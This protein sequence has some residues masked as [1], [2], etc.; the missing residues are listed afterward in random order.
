MVPFRVLYWLSDFFYFLCYYV[1]RYRR[2][3]VY[4]NIKSVFPEKSEVERK[5]LEKESYQWFCDVILESVKGFRMSVQDLNEHMKYENLELLRKYVDEKRSVFLDMAHTG[6]WEWVPNIYLEYFKDI[7]GAELYRHVKNKH[8][9]A[10]LLKAR[11]R[12]GTLVIPKDKATRPLLKVI[13]DGKVFAIGLVADQSP[14]RKNLHFWVPFLNHDTPFLQGPERLARLFKSAV[15]YLDFKRVSRGYYVCTIR[16]ITD[17]ASK[18]DEGYVTTKFAQLLESSI[19]RDP[20]QW[21]WTH[22]RWKYD[23]AK[24]KKS[25]DVVSDNTIG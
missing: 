23:P 7:V 13:R 12:F 16:D 5:K 25:E 1:V 18:T 6:A 22:R 4:S 3:V 21:F 9:D 24:Y 19:R 15:I 10:F 2:S 17:D 11:Q 20:A 8:L 14:S